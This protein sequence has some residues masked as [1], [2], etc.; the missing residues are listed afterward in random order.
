MRYLLLS[1][2]L[3]TPALAESQRDGFTCAVL[4]SC[5]LQGTCT[6]G[7]EGFDLAFLGGGLEVAMN[8][9]HLSP[10]YDGVLQTAAWESAGRIYQLRFTGD[11]AGLLTASPVE[12]SADEAALMTIH[13]SPE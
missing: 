5:D 8:G 6:E 9:D 11:G 4:R 10:V 7:G 2:L 3:A 12:G 1:L 13:C